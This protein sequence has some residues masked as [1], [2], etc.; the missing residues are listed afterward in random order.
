MGSAGMLG[1]LARDCMKWTMLYRKMEK[2]RDVKNSQ[3]TTTP[4]KKQKITETIA[5]VHDAEEQPVILVH[6][7][8]Y[9]RKIQIYMNTM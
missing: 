5:S 3:T 2:I 1:K 6:V 8:P 9:L 7:L 4:A